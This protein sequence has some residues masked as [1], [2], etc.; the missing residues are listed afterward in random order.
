[1]EKSQNRIVLC[2]P[3]ELYN[4]LQQQATVFPCLSDPNY[5]L[6]L[7][8]RQNNDYNE[9]HIITSKKAPV[10]ESGDF[11]LPYDAE[12]ECKQHVIVVDS[13]TSSLQEKG[14]AL[15]CAKLLADMG[16]RNPV[17]V[18]RGGYEEF[19]ALYP[20][21]RTHKIIYMPQELDKLEPYPV[22][23]LPGRLY[24]GTTAQATRAHVRK[25]LKV[26]A[27]ILNTTQTVETTE[28][29]ADV[30]HIS[31]L[32]EDD[33]DI[34]SHFTGSCEFIGNHLKDSNP[35]LVSSDHG[36]SRSVA[37]ILAYLMNHYK[38]P[39]KEAYTHL[40][41]CKKNIRPR[42]TFVQQ[43]SKWE[44]ELFQE[45]VTDITDPNY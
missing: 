44:E 39:L 18:L 14:P 4:I 23:V 5:L 42:R 7:D 35:V 25:D 15:S 24:L 45:I 3:T 21:L 33:V 20:F 19:S 22:E 12:L 9:S 11:L 38:W 16:S 31:I 32:D 2:E 36:L 30:Q 40:Q 10:S 29:K 26:K 41:G 17:K 27:I 8:A 28:L 43:L 1:M 37:L 6:L 13:N 34:F